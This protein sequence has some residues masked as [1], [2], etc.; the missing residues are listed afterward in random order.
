MTDRTVFIVSGGT[1]DETFTYRFLEKEHR[2]Q[3]VIIAAEGGVSFCLRFG[4][5][6]DLAVGDFDSAGKAVLEEVRM[7]GIPVNLFPSEKDETDTGIA[8]QTALSYDPSE[9]VLF[10][11]TG[12][13]LDHV[14]ANIAIAARLAEDPKTSKIRLRMIDPHNELS[15]HTEP[16][17][18]PK[19]DWHYCSFF[20]WTDTVTG[21]TLEGMKYPLQDYTLRRSDS[22]GT[23]NEIVREEARITFRDGILLCIL[24]C[25]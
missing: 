18:I 4:I 22:I 6:P 5:R 9:I 7:A 15:L 21:L 20:S 2:A 11:A 12:T 19:T 14:T 3:D 16:F 13:R 10:G 17:T 24:S 23:S 1:L 25:D 8:I